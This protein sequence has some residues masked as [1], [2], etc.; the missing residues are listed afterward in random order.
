MDRTVIDR[1]CAVPG[2]GACTDAER[3]AARA[4]HDSLRARGQQTWVEARWIRPQR[5]ASLVLHAM[6]AVAGAL[7]SAYAPVVG[8]AMAGAAAL[9]LAVEA[10]GATAPLAR[11]FARRATQHVLTE[12]E[13]DGITLLVAAGYDAPRGPSRLV[14]TG[15]RLLE[16]LPLRP[17][18]WAALCCAAIALGAVGRARGLDGTWI[19]AIQLTGVVVLVAAMG[20]AIDAMN[21]PWS[22]GAGRA[23]AVAVALALLD[24]LHRDPPRALAPALLLIGARGA[25]PESLRAHLRAERARPRDTVLLEIGPCGGGPP[26]WAARHSQLR[27]AAAQAAAAL[28]EARQG[29]DPP[30][31]ARRIPA[32]AIGG[33]PPAGDEPDALDPAALDATLDLALGVVDA[34]D[35]ALSQPTGRTPSAVRSSTGSENEQ[36][37]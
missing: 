3:R 25:G 8:A 27:A 31:G 24:E 21:A 36:D 33:A 12:P 4:L 5:R 19:G 34:L 17:E 20:A 6:L 2:R 22:R 1:L 29:G 18:A 15:Q 14:R 32:I 26:K 9:S 16:S 35:A 23:A 10:A 11:F 13:G 30:G 37:P 28:G 7:V